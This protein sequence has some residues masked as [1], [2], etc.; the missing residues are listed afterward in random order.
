MAVIDFNQVDYPSATRLYEC[1]KCWALVIYPQEHQKW[2]DELNL[3]FED[4]EEE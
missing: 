1:Q 3:R 4:G 2:H